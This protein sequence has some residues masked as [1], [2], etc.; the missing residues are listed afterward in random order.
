MS[1]TEP[2]AT[3]QDGWLRRLGRKTLT[4]LASAGALA[5]MF[6]AAWRGI[7][8]SGRQRGATLRQ[9]YHIG[10]RSFAIVVVALGFFGMVMIYQI[11]L[12]LDR[13][14]GD[15]S[16]VGAQFA[17]ILVLDLGPSLTAT[18]LAIRVGAGIA[19][20]LGSMKIT[21]QIDALRMCGVDPVSYL[22]SPRLLAGVI[23]TVVLSTFGIVSSYAAGALSAWASFDLDPRIFHDL[24][25]VKGIHLI[26]GTVKALA[27]GMS[28][29]VIA[30]FCGLRAR[31]SSEGVGKA[32][33]AAVIGS[34]FAVL[35]WDFLISTAAILLLGD[36]L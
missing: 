4:L 31:G 25:Q 5:I 29:P 20:E 7:F 22:V 26:I 19:A 34:T 14:T 13:I 23:M 2:T 6:I 9:M 35:A 1:T 11:C 32:T 24:G 27:Y 21:E 8:A 36:E 33:T 18:M 30:S 10:N 12:Q 28:I 15:V 3:P 17:R 16:L